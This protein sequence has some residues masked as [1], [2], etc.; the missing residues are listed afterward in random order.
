M[1]KTF[2]SLLIVLILIGVV[3]CSQFGA[4]NFGGDYTHELPKGEKLV[5]VTWK[6]DTLWYLTEPMKAEDEAETYKFNADSVFGVF[7]GTV[8][9]V[10]SK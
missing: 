5:N 6:D 9:I 7:E 3:G 4:K 2:L 10:E 8:T 1:K